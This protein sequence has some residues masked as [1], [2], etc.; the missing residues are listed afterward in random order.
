M[1]YFWELLFFIKQNEIAIEKPSFG[2]LILSGLSVKHV[3]PLYSIL[4]N[5]NPLFIDISSFWFSSWENNIF[6]NTFFAIKQFVLLII[7]SL[8]FNTNC[9]LKSP[10]I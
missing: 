2:N 5:T 8:E 7:F 4:L 9:S 3:I 1:L 6:K 10:N